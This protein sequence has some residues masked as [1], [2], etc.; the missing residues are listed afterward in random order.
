LQ[1]QI[2][3]HLNVARPV[4]LEAQGSVDTL[5]GH[6]LLGGMQRDDLLPAPPDLIHRTRAVRDQYFYAERAVVIRA[7]HGLQP[8]PA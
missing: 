2:S 5:R 7:T 6:H 4:T 1:D 8:G 3:V